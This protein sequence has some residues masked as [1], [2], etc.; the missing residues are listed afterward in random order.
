MSD[1]HN[2]GEATLKSQKPLCLFQHKGFCD[3][4]SGVEWS[5]EPKPSLFITTILVL[6]LP[7][8]ILLV[9]SV[10]HD[11]QWLRLIFPP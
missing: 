10:L 8:L 6:V 7:L 2:F 4:L 1:I 3:F 11:N 9:R 5:A